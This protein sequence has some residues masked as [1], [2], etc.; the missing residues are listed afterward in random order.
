MYSVLFVCTA[1]IC[2]S[3]VAMGILRSK[4]RQEDDGEWR[5]E[6]AGVW[7]REGAP[8]EYFSQIIVKEKGI[9]L[10][11]HRSQR[12]SAD[13]MKEFNLILTMEM[14]QK[15]G[16]KAAYP[17]YAKKVYLITE[18]VDSQQ[19]IVDPYGSSLHDFQ[20]TARELEWI[21]DK[22]YQRIRQLAEGKTNAKAKGKRS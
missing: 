21:L 11:Q 7:A 3:P 18:M 1:N 4:T 13:L 10:S 15:E 17:K 8:A 19:D 2:R 6:S 5:I 22:G 20:D 12:I 9:D 14:G 16:L